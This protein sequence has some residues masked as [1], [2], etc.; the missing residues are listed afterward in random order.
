MEKIE[1]FVRQ[2]GKAVLDK[3]VQNPA[4]MYQ[5]AYSFSKFPMSNNPGPNFQFL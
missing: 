3:F 4:R 5:I 2:S 1:S